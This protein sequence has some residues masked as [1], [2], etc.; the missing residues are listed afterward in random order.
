MSQSNMSDNP[1]P[2]CVQRVESSDHVTNMSVEKGIIWGI[3]MHSIHK[4]E[5]LF[6]L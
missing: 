2:P 3:S 1:P 4:G 5:P 6:F